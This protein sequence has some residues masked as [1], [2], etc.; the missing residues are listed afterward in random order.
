MNAFDGSSYVDCGG[1]TTLDLAT[2]KT[3]AYY[4][5]LSAS[6]AA[7]GGLAHISFSSGSYAFNMARTTVPGYYTTIKPANASSNAFTFGTAAAANTRER[8]VVRVTSAPTSLAIGDWAAWINGVSQTVAAGG[9]FTPQGSGNTWLGWDNADSKYSG[10]LD[11]F[12]VFEGSLSDA[13]VAS[14]YANPWQIF[15]P[16]PRRIWAPAAA[17]GPNVTVALTGQ[18]V[19]A[20]AGTLGLSSAVAVS[21]AAVTVSAGTIV[22]SL[23]MALAGIVAN[24]S[25]GT[26][27]QS[28]AIALTGAAVTV[29]TGTLT[30]SAGSNI[31]VA[32]TGQAVT[33]SAGTV[34]PSVALALAGQ[35][36]TASAGTLAPGVAVAAS[37]QAVT[38]SAGT[39]VQSRTI[40]L[41]GLAVT[42]GGGVLVASGGSAVAADVTATVQAGLNWKALVQRAWGKDYTK[43]DPGYEFTGRKFDDNPRGGP[44]E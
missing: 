27:V 35:A 6:P 14:Y 26:V 24:A 32:L 36:V 5:R 15:A 25:T 30:Y 34:I 42:A 38:A 23:S 19:T 12:I 3:F 13:E 44:Y 9:G 41:S 7:F 37:G 20:S 8:V 43:P 18:A 17:G 28:A 31:S 39:L 11:E 4:S 22:P 21:G 33:V 16:L 1:V 40:A 29:S 2:P 10:L